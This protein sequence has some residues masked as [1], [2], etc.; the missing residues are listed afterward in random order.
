MTTNIQ[1]WHSVLVLLGLV[2]A[3]LVRASS[4][5]RAHEGAERAASAAR[6]GPAQTRRLAA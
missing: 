2:G 6:E 3:T 4:A 1:L 5:L